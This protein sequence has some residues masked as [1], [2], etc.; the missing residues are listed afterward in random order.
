VAA[1]RSPLAFCWFALRPLRRLTGHDETLGG[2]FALLRGI[3]W[4]A[5]IGA[6]ALGARAPGR[7]AADASFPDPPR[8]DQPRLRR[9]RTGT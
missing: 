1:G 6:S 9:W 3:L 2:E 8:F 4:R 7:R 5:L